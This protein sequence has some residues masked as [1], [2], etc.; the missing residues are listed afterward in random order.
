MK[1]IVMRRLLIL[2][3]LISLALT[4]IQVS[5]HSGRQDE[6]GGHANT[7]SGEYH[8]QKPDCILP[9]NTTQ[10]DAPEK[11][12]IATFN[13]QIFGKSKLKKTA[14]MAELASIVRKYDLVAIQEIKDI[15]GSVAPKFL[16]VINVDGAEY[17]YIISKRSGQNINDKKSQE[18][19]AYFYN[20]KTIASTD[21]GVLF[22]DSKEDYFQREPYVA[23]F[24]VVG[25]NFDFTIFTI[26][27]RPKSALPE[28]DALKHVFSWAKNHYENEEDIIALG[29]FNASCN[30]TDD[31]DLD[32]LTIHGTGYVWVVPH[33]ADTNFSTKS[34][35]AY[36]R[37][38]L[39]DSIKTDFTGNWGIDTVTNKKVSDHF[40]VW[41]EFYTT[42]DY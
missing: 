29:D 36:D 8:C 11:I 27:T 17:D 18:Q 14:V 26:H 19:Y 13:I 28:V 10:Y 38:V 39:T 6:N 23:N 7:S 20:T 9:D 12:S 2:G 5:A 22:D 32:E 33:V 4:A 42:K 31:D 16:E 34:D 21:D 1:E 35:C 24:K 37:I 15:S 41:A 30:Y 3:L 25:G 40:P